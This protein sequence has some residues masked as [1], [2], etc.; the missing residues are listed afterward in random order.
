MEEMEAERR[1]QEQEEEELQSA[2]EAADG[3]TRSRGPPVPHPVRTPHLSHLG[4]V[5]LTCNF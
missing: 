3:E 4:T 5:E 2:L 1:L